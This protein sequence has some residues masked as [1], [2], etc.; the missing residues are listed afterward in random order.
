MK[1]SKIWTFKAI[2]VP[3]SAI[4]SPKSE[5]SKHFT[6]NLSS[7]KTE[8]EIEEK[9]LVGLQLVALMSKN[10]KRLKP[11]RIGRNNCWNLLRKNRA[12][13]RNW[14]S[15]GKTRREFNGTAKGNSWRRRAWRMT[16]ANVNGSYGERRH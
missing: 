13:T 14:V 10:S 2:K 3:I 9:D 5:L 11:L 8:T 6:S 1:R 16:E 15:W 12:K 4:N 7:T